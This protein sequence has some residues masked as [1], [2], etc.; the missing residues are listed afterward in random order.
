M[1]GNS[2][3]IV[4]DELRFLE[5]EISALPGTEGTSML[6]NERAHIDAFPIWIETQNTIATVG[7][8]QGI[9]PVFGGLIRKTDLHPEAC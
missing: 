7:A 3:A 5:K 8:V 2:V 9:A 6:F 1:N 4:T